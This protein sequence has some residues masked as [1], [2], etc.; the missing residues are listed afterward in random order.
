[1]DVHVQ[2]E[3]PRARRPSQTA[4]ADLNWEMSSRTLFFGLQSQIFQQNGSSKI[5]TE[6]NLLANE[7]FCSPG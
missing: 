5:P 4:I 1:M 2:F 3:K 7:N 6:L